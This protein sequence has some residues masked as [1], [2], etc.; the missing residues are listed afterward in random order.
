MPKTGTKCLHIKLGARCNAS[1]TI[2]VLTVVSMKN[3]IFWDTDVP[4]EHVLQMSVD[5]QWPIRHYIAKERTLHAYVVFEVLTA[6][7][8]KRSVFWDIISCK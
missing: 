6:V 8:M 2:E 1:S 4:G 7:V 3:S 5:F